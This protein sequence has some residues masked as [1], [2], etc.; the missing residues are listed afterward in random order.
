MTSRRYKEKDVEALPARGAALRRLAEA[1]NLLFQMRT[2]PVSA[3]PDHWLA[4]AR[5]VRCA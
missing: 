2:L 1:E 3:P 4:A 5:D